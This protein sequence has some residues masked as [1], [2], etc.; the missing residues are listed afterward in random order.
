MTAIDAGFFAIPRETTLADLAAELDISDQAVSDHLR[1]AQRNLLQAT[2][3]DDPA[4]DFGQ[5][6][7]SR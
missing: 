4:A 2:V 7:D 5:E 6:S 1:R 3:L